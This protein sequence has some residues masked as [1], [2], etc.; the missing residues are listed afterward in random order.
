MDAGATRAGILAALASLETVE[1]QG[2][3]FVYFTGWGWMQNAG[4]NAYLMPYDFR[5]EELAN[6]ISADELHAVL[7]ASP[8][9]VRWL[10]SMGRPAASLPRSPV[11]R[12][13][14]LVCIRRTRP[15]PL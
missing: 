12:G 1:P 7:C 2:Q 10:C 3:V 8:R 5:A 15:A 14:H 6:G 4:P 11:A 13:V 9:L